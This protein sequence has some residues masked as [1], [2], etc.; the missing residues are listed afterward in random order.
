MVVAAR[1]M[2][3][4]LMRTPP[5]RTATSACAAAAGWAAAPSLACPLRPRLRRWAAVCAV[6]SDGMGSNVSGQSRGPQRVVFLGTPAVAAGVLRALIDA[7]DVLGAKV[8]AAVTSPAKRQGRGKQLTATPVETMARERGIPHVLTPASARDPEFLD[9]IRALNPDV[10]VTAAYGYVLPEEFLGTPRL[11]TLNIHPSLLP[12]WRGAAPVQRTLEA[13]DP[14]TGV[15]VAYTVY[16]MDA[17]P[18]AA[19]VEHAPGKDITSGE[20]LEHLFGLGTNVLIMDVLP[21]VFSGALTQ[22]A[23]IPQD[24]NKATKAKKLSKEEGVLDFASSEAIV[25]HNRVRAFA[26]WPGTVAT[27]DIGGDLVIV[28]VT[29]TRTVAPN[30]ESVVREPGSVTLTKQGV[31][32]ACEGGTVLELVTVQPPNKKAVNASD[33]MHGMQ[34]KSVKAVTTVPAAA[35][36]APPR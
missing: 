11:G 21:R 18:I 7:E 25:L 3:Q 16:A 4:I 2:A 9:A 22:E 36:S 15:S 13:G 12:L 34:G 35:Q 27:F 28:R 10:C 29:Q 20:L 23:A 5:A 19:Q 6:G 30:V 1:G 24:D 14:L 33:W 17:G 26:G 8:V 31:F 32:V